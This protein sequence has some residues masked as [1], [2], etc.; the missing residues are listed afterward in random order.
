MAVPFLL[1]IHQEVT[2][3]RAPRQVR[4]SSR[5]GRVLSF[6]AL[7]VVFGLTLAPLAQAD[8]V[9]NSQP[10]GPVTDAD[11]DVLIRVRQ[12]GL[13]EGPISAQIALRSQNPK[14]RAVAQQLSD[15]HHHLD[16]ETLAAAATLRVGLPETPTPQQRGWMTQIL[17]AP[18]DQ[19]DQLYVDITRAAHGTVFTIIAG[20]R[21][22]TQNDVMRQ[23]AQV[24]ID[25]VMRHMTL[26]ESTGLSTSISLVTPVSGPTSAVAI[27]PSVPSTGSVLLGMALAGLAVLATFYL[28][29]V[30]G[31]DPMAR[32]GADPPVIETRADQLSP[33]ELT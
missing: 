31:Q 23:F 22:A 9:D 6:S 5:L 25:Y 10:S 15:E 4:P 16:M 13:W 2:T 19:A 27:T 21:A 1:F 32:T 17:A 24:G 14:V 30:L 29:R 3:M 11:R 28:V 20:E 33:R 18:A 26:L 12:A 8:P 7:A